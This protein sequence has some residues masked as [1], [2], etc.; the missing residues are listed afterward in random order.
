MNLRKGISCAAQLFL[1]LIGNSA[2]FQNGIFALRTNQ[3][4]SGRSFA[5][6]P[7]EWLYK[8]GYS[9]AT[10]EKPE[11]AYDHAGFAPVAVPQFLNRI[12]WWLDDSEDFKKFEDTRLKKLGF[13]TE[14]AEDGW[15]HLTLD[16]PT[17]AATKRL[18]LEL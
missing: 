9:V 12:H 13:D 4:E 8:P 16:L 7:A 2:E 10:N 14:R 5:L 18:F 6:T 1:A 15:Y 11:L 17:I 3:L